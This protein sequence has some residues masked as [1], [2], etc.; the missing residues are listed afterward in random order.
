[1]Y[2]VYDLIKNQV[3]KNF[4]RFIY[5]SSLACF[6]CA[7]SDGIRIFNVEPFAQKSFLGK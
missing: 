3:K 1:M 4:N 5:F 7:T 2:S 6:I